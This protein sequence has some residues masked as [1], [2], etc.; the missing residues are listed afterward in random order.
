[1]HAVSD[2][3]LLSAWEW[4][5]GRSP[6]QRALALLSIPSPDSPSCDWAAKPI[7]ERD[8]SLLRLRQRTFG[9][10]LTSVAHCPSCGEQ[11]ELTCDVAQLLMDGSGPVVEPL[12]RSFGN[13]LVQFRLPNSHDLSAIQDKPSLEDARA[14]LLSRCLI[15]AECDGVICT[16]EQLPEH[17]TLAIAHSMA[18]A[19][20]QGDVRFDC[21]CPHCGTSWESL[22]DI[23]SYLWTELSVW[24]KRTL[25]EVHLLASAYGWREADI[26]AMSSARRQLYLKLIES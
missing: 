21:T 2:S 6:I 1:M 19:D 7:G 23:V 8:A 15:S 26:L 9:S 25:R 16:P 17:V 12:T 10:R 3:E 13:Y 24:A 4:G 14:T 5:L 18:E 20:P 11:A 22:F